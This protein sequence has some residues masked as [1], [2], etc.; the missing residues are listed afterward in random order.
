VDPTVTTV[1]KVSVRGESVTDTISPGAADIGVSRVP[2]SAQ[3]GA[4][5]A[6][7][8]VQASRKSSSVIRTRW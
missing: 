2:S 8:V 6:L 1:S 5:D 7:V 3:V 4:D